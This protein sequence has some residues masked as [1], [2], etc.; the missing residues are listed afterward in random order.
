MRRYYVSEDG[1]EK[2]DMVVLY[3][4]QVIGVLIGVVII[5]VWARWIW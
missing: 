5:T 1:E 3:A 2:I 4:C